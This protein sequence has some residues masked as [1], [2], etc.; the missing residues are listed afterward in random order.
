MSIYKRGKTYW[1]KFMWKRGYGSKINPST[2]P[3]HS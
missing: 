2:Q 3:K 1:Y